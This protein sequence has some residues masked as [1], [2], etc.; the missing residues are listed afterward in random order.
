MAH[1][2][3][4]DL[5]KNIAEYRNNQALIARAER[6]NTIL[7]RRIQKL[8]NLDEYYKREERAKRAHRLITKGEAI[9]NIL[10]ESK[11]MEDADFYQLMQRILSSAEAK[12]IWKIYLDAH[13]PLNEE[14]DP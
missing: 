13:P 7:E 4:T 3:I 8:E 12:K 11:G 14:G 5:P 1:Q 10:P 9:E 2:Y 6:E